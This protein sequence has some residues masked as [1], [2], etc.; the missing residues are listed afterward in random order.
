MTKMQTLACLVWL[1]KEVQNLWPVSPLLPRQGR[2]TRLALPYPSC[3][4]HAG[5]N[6][7]HMWLWRCPRQTAWGKI[8]VVCHHLE[9]RGKS[10]PSMLWLHVKGR[11]H[12][13]KS[14][15]RLGNVSDPEQQ[16]GQG[17]LE[18]SWT[19]GSGSVRTAKEI[20]NRDRK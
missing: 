2:D 15:W 14:A 6:T 20:R 11:H 16:R 12:P 10:V 5:H 8:K 19:L 7:D 4:G 13:L 18:R 1:S 17:Y 9:G 3:G